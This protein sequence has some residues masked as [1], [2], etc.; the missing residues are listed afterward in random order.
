MR[1]KLSA[2]KWPKN[3]VF[4]CCH[5]VQKF[6]TYNFPPIFIFF[7]YINADETAE[8]DKNLFYISVLEF[9]FTSIFRLGGPILSK[10]SKSLYVTSIYYNISRKT[11]YIKEQ[12]CIDRWKK[13]SF[14]YVQ[15][16]P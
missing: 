12:K 3:G 14:V 7:A 16:D 4:D 10:K 5:C 15:G 1:K 8:K 11:L 9:H 2:K 13:R 6:S